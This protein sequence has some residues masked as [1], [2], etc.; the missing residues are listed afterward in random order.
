MP[1]APYDLT[2]ADAAELLRVHPDTI[3]RWAEAG[4]LH[5]WRTPGGQRR[6]RRSDVMALL[7]AEPSGAAS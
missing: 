6:F 7:P 4:D 5:S 1:S 3:R 2:V